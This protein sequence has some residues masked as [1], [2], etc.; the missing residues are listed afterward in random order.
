MSLMGTTN[1]QKLCVKPDI[2]LKLF[3]E[4]SLMTIEGSGHVRL[5]NYYVMYV[6]F[7]YIYMYG[8]GCF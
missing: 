2:K 6:K 1:Y 8:D 5:N 7:I 3:T 4:R